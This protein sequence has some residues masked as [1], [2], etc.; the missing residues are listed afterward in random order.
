MNFIWFPAV[1]IFVMITIEILLIFL[2]LNLFRPR[3][4]MID[5]NFYNWCFQF[6]NE[7]DLFGIFVILI[8]ESIPLMLPILN[9]NLVCP[10]YSNNKNNYTLA[11]F[12]KVFLIPIWHNS[13]LIKYTTKMRYS[14]KSKKK[15]YA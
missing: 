5:V 15:T 13:I 1:R 11:K 4:L 9:E 14:D 8:S 3:L 2:A 12:S 6:K 7:N 10:P